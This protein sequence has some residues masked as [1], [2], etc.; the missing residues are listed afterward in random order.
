MLP[1]RT[2]GALATS[3][4]Q[5]VRLTALHKHYQ[6]K[7]YKSPL[8]RPSSSDA[9]GRQAGCKGSSAGISSSTSSGT[10]KTTGKTA[11]KQYRHCRG[12]NQHKQH[13]QRTAQSTTTAH[14]VPNT[15]A[16][17]STPTTHAAP[18]SHAAPSTPTAHAAPTSHADELKPRGHQGDATNNASQALQA[19]AQERPPKWLL[20]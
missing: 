2:A 18:T 3:P 5:A 13:A 4:E 20:L 8:Y 11:E 10:G 6:N 19:Q 15:H 16:A 7:S 9:T 1:T 17:P 12:H 14:A